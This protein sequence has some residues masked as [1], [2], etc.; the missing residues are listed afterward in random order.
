[1]VSPDGKPTAPFHIKDDFAVGFWRSRYEGKRCYYITHSGIEYI[2]MEP[3][4]AEVLE[5]SKEKIDS[6]FEVADSQ[7][8]YWL[9]LYQVVYPHWATIGRIKGYPTVGK[10]THEYLFKKAIAFDKAHHPFLQAGFLWMNLGFG[11]DES[12]PEWHVKRAPISE[13][14]EGF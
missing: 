12:V 1:M 2:F 6:I 9:A 4:E 14:K 11:C 5:L 7:H 13:Y 10:E 8:Y 3:E